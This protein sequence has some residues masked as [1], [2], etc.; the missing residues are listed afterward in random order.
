MKKFLIILLLFALYAIPYALNPSTAQA[1]HIPLGNECTGDRTHCTPPSICTFRPA[2]GAYQCIDPVTAGPGGVFGQIQPPQALQNLGIGD[3][4]ISAF[5]NN[6][7]RLIYII[8]I[9]VLLFMFLWGALEWLTSGGDKEKISN[10]QKRIINAIIGVVLF[11]IAY[12]VL[13]VVGVFTGF[14]FFT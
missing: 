9:V 6:L 3:V 8:A 5:F 1:I 7:I 11:A 14:T 13:K 10:A 12:P 2:S 4:G